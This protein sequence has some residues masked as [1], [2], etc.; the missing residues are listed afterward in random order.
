MKKE[1]ESESFK[2]MV[3]MKFNLSTRNG[4]RFS[5]YQ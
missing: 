4:T 5:Q 1:I 2:K 3:I